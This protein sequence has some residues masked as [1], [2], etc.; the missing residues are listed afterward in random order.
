VDSPT[1]ENDSKGR[2]KRN[3]FRLDVIIY[4]WKS[5]LTEFEEFN[6]N[7]LFDIVLR[8]FIKHPNFDVVMPSSDDETVINRQMIDSVFLTGLARMTPRYFMSEEEIRIQRSFHE[9]V[10]R[11]TNDGYNRVSKTS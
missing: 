5:E 10:F 11:V 3:I 9:D 1:D 7:Q 8:L 4:R 6:Y 2:V